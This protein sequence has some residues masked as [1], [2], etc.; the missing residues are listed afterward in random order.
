MYKFPIGVII[1]SFRVPPKEAVLK[2]ASIDGVEG[3]QVYSTRG[4]MAPENLSKE[5]RKEFLDLVK[6]NG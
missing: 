6:S 2:A 1:D 3:I 5:A 4:E